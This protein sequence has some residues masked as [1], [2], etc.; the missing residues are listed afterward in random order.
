M[1]RTLLTVFATAAVIVAPN[2]QEKEDRTLLS[3][4]QAGVIRLV[5]R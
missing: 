5:K 3:N 2:A 4:D 1:T